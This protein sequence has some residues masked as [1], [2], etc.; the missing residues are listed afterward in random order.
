MCDFDKVHAS[1]RCGGVQWNA[2]APEF[3]QGCDCGY[4]Q[5]KGSNWTSCDPNEFDIV[6]RTESV[7]GQ[8][9]DRHSPR[10]Y[11][12]KRCGTPLWTWTADPLRDHTDKRHTEYE[13]PILNWN[14]N[15][16][17]QG[18]EPVNEERVETAA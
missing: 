15:L 12:C 16:V 14:V 13:N 11:H 10:H 9:F 4:C 18:A 7:S 2:P 1:C 6:T 5:K 17:V 8:Q 3:K